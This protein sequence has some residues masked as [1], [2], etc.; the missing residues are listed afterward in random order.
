MVQ[1]MQAESTMDLFDFET[2]KILLVKKQPLL[3]L[4]DKATYH[5]PRKKKI[6]LA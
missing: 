4:I 6:S 2:R 3:Q 5:L 1:L